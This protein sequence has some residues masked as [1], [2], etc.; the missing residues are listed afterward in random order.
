MR[1]RLVARWMALTLTALMAFT[2]EGFAQG[3]TVRILV[4]FPAGQA[5]DLV[6]RLIAERLRAETGDNVIVENRPGQGGSIALAAL[7]RSEPDGTTMVLGA[8]ASYVANPHLYPSVGYDT[9]R[10][11]APVAL[12]GELPLVLITNP[13][14]PAKTLEELVAHARA[15]AGKLTHSSSGAGTLSHL[16]MEHLKRAAGVEILHVPYQ[17]SVRAVT[18]VL[19]GRIDIAMETIATTIPHV[20]SGS[21]R[22]IAVGTEGRIP[23][24]A[25]T[26]T[27]AETY[28]GFHASAWLGVVYPARTSRDVVDRTAAA[29]AAISKQPEIRAKLSSMGAIPRSSTPEEFAAFLTA[30]HARWGELIRQLGLANRP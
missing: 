21:A 28:P 26:P 29:L 12:V 5:T 14:V 1:L 18:D 19:S 7:A 25:D 6:A 24:L 2:A 15:N 8:L 23:E 10:D 4:G 3:R 20:Q 30:E 27:V 9:L 17:G 22:L 16:A 11:F 13:S